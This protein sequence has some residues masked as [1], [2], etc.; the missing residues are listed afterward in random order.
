MTDI[1]T[2]SHS[3]QTYISDLDQQWDSLLRA[4]QERL[5]REK[6]ILELQQKFTSLELALRTRDYHQLEQTLTDL[7]DIKEKYI[8]KGGE[9]YLQ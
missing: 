9:F 4:T 5:H 6:S 3:L 7:F 1:I 2:Y 8:V